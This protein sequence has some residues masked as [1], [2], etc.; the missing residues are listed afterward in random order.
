MAVAP[1]IINNPDGTIEL[2]G[3]T[4]QKYIIDQ[5]RKFQIVTSCQNSNA[6]WDG[7]NQNGSIVWK[8]SIIEV[9][10][11]L[12]ALPSTL[13]TVPTFTIIKDTD[14]LFTW[15]DSKLEFLD[16]TTGFAFDPAVFDASKVSATVIAPGVGRFHSQVLPAP[17]LRS[18]PTSPLYY[19]WNLGGYLLQGGG[20][21]L[22]TLRFRVKSDFYFPVEQTTDIR[23]VASANG[24][25]SKVNGDAARLGDIRNNANK[26]LFGP[27]PEYKVSHLLEEPDTRII[28][29]QE[30]GVKIF[31][32]PETLPQ[33]IWTV[34]TIF[35]WDPTII[36]FMG[37]DKTGGKASMQSSIQMPG[38]GSINES[39]I[40]KDGNAHHNW[41]SLLGDKKPIS[42]KT[43]I[44][45]LKFKA[46]TDFTETTVE[47]CEKNDPRFA[48]LFISDDAGIFGSR[49]PGTMVTGARKNAV[50]KGVL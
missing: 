14:L 10:I 48:G 2:K 30:F 34:S 26:I 4:L 39:A 20:R 31:A 25:T 24:E 17:E 19:Q 32:T 50:I 41:L 42:G 35:G 27:A 7:K 47:L 18:P 40:P 46:L 43:L 44:A 16:S 22:G 1:Q 3:N 6:S 21:V 9:R 29:G 15:D 37:V 8:G 23:I 38:A 49:V 36:E 11:S 33:V 45:T 12:N 13:T 5:T 28:K